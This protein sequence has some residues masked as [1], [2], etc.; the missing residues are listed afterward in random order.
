[1]KNSSVAVV[2]DLYRGI[3]S[4]IG[5]KLKHAAIGFGGGY[6]D[7]LA[8]LHLIIHRDIEVLEREA[9]RRRTITMRKASNAEGRTGPNTAEHPARRGLR[10]V[11]RRH[12]KIVP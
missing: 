11:D 9:G 6:L 2:I 5:C 8:G 1:M 7:F 10:G 4:T 12:R 3:N